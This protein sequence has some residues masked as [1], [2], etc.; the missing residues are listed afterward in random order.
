MCILSGCDYLK[1]I[2]GIGIQKARKAVDHEQD[3][4]WII[5]NLGVLVGNL[6]L[7]I[8]NTYKKNVSGVM[9]IFKYHPVIDPLKKEIR[10]LCQ[11]NWPVSDDTCMPRL[12]CI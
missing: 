6:S 8:P 12:V 3:I 9:H 4:D 2:P 1:S 11:C 10:P 7:T 5:D